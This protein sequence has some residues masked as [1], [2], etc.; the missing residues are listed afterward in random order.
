MIKFSRFIYT[1]ILIT[2]SFDIFLVLNVG[3]FNFRANQ[4]FCAIFFICVLLLI[5]K[6]ELL[7]SWPL[8]FSFLLAWFLFIFIFIPN[9]SYFKF[10][11]GYAFWLFFSI[12]LI[13]FTVQFFNNSHSVYKL[14]RGY[15]ISFFLVALFGLFQFFSPLLHLGAPLITQWWFPGLLPRINGFS[16]EPSFFSTYLLMGWVLCAYFLK[17]KTYILS[18]KWLRI[19]FF[20]ETLAIILSSSRMGVIMM[21]LWWLQYPALLVFNLITL[22]INRINLRNTLYMV[23]LFLISSVF[24][25]IFVDLQ[26][27]SFLLAGTG[28]AG[29]ASHSVTDRFSGASVLWDLFIKSPFIGYSLGG[30]PPAIGELKGIIVNTTELVKE[31]TGINVFMEILAASGVIGMIPILFYLYKLVRD[32]FRLSQK[33]ED[34]F[35]KNILL[36]MIWAFLFELAILQFN[37][38]ILRPYFWIHIAV[39]SSL[40]CVVKKEINS[41]SGPQ[42]KTL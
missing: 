24:I 38:N 17:T 35:K 29:T 31:N 2:S 6:R 23:F 37:Q 22:K 25:L 28:L 39:L 20:T 11:I 14:I 3:G 33:I 40:Y 42:P 18:V 15:L 5:L 8:S 1:L 9:T 32:P 34:K 41:N 21:L 27:I 13:F 7:V 26:K 30:L 19:I 36:G 16:Y 10:S 4:L 12:L